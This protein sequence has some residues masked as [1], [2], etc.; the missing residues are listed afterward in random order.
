MSTNDIDRLGAGCGAYRLV[1]LVGHGG[2]GSVYLAE[3]ADG[4][5]QQQVAIKLLHH[6]GSEPAFRDLFLRE[7]RILARLQHPAIARVLD[8]GHTDGGQPYLAMEYVDGIPIDAYADQLDLR[9]KLLLFLKVLEAVSYAHRNLIVHR[10]LKPS[11]ILV[12]RDGRP[13]L[14][15]FGIAKILDAQEHERTVVG[16]PA[17][18][19]QY[20][21][22]EQI[23]G[24][25]ITTASDV[26][27]L[28]VLLYRLLT[29]RLPYELPG[30]G[31]SAVHHAVCEAD[32]L[33]PRLGSDLDAI[34]LM[35]LRKE[36]ARRYS[37]AQHLAVDLECVLEHRPISARPDTV[38]YRAGKFIR[39]HRFGLTAAAL[40][41]AAI[42]G[43]A[44]TAAYQARIAQR[45]FEDVRR[46]A[47]A[48][49]F[50]VHDEVARLEGSTGVRA[51]IV[52]T[53]LEYLDDLARSAGRDPSLQKEIADA[54]QKIGDAEGFP[55]QPNL[56][57][58]EDALASYRK[59]GDIYRRLAAADP[60]YVPDLA[61]YD[62]HY[63]GLLRFGRDPKRARE[64]TA[65]AI[66]MFDAV[67]VRRAWDD[68]SE[69]TYIRAW[70]TLGDLDD[71]M[72][73]S[74]EAL[75][76]YSRCRELAG[77]AMKQHRD[78]KALAR[79]SEADERIGTAAQSLGY[80]SQAREAFAED[81]ALLHELLA[82]EPRNPRLRKQL[83]LMYQFRS[84]LYYD[85]TE[86]NLGEPKRALE[87][88]KRYLD[89]SADMARKDPKNTAAQFSHAVAQYRISVLLRE[90]DVHAAIAAARDSVRIF[91]ELLASGKHDYLTVSRRAR[92]MIRLG[93]AQLR[94]G[95]IEEAL[96]T[97]DA[98]LTVDRQVVEQTPADT[99]QRASL[100]WAEILA[101]QASAGSGNFQHAEKLLRQARAE[102][103]SIAANQELEKVIP[104]ATVEEALGALYASRRRTEDASAC[105]QRLAGLWRR[106]P[107]NEYVRRQ[108]AE[109][110][111][112]L[113]E[114]QDKVTELRVLGSALWDR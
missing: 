27:S 60:A 53:A 108:K 11:N 98:A 79:L 24:E 1:R 8:A 41:L 83:A 6:G 19:P 25:T 91:D 69:N 72:G 4:E 17:W 7:R 51:T 104:L 90:S 93:Q 38:Y 109:A 10:D 94:A 77:A 50:D 5:L 32:P 64:L 56:G 103:E 12:D 80:L 9:G 36:P 14:V 58:T 106:F 100:V 84:S 65:T 95:Q 99:E 87:D 48:L 102:A 66:R 81:E 46:L 110:A 43:G 62:L 54:Y 23:R 29:G 89:L 96:R 35:A 44:G 86:P 59:A 3:R 68:R 92:A 101:A 49:I 45:R 82:A 73:H 16:L 47:H 107:D 42:A 20:A 85:D 75:E 111:L 63:A 74:R 28:G 71:D 61:A 39:R 31:P 88:A 55:T 105:Y 13:R 30:P 52:R 22:P 97:A 37:S 34:L 26:Y 70:C 78:R 113:R 112:R 33:P 21:S 15:D 2:M 76:E 40:I 67:R 57:R 18:T 114:V